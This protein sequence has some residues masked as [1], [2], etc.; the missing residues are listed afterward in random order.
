MKVRRGAVCVIVACLAAVTAILAFPPSASAA[1]T[2]APWEP[3][4]SA[5]TGT[6][7][8]YDGTGAQIFSGTTADAPLATYAG[9]SA[10]LGSGDASAGLELCTPSQTTAPAAWP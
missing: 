8:F 4:T 2:P 9:W 10:T 1:T 7:T 3:I 6:L 5:E